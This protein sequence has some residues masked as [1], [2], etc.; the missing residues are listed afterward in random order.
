M[1]Y[2][3]VAERGQWRIYDIEDL[4]STFDPDQPRSLRKQIQK[5][6][7]EFAHPPEP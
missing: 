1:Q 7:E 3:L 4:S 6:L 2:T 5:D